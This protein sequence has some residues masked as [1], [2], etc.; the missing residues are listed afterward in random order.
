MISINSN[1]GIVRYL[2]TIC[3]LTLSMIILSGCNSNNNPISPVELT[4]NKSNIRLYDGQPWKLK[5]LI[6]EE[7]EEY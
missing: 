4:A 3:Y 1:G 7:V 2:I 5:Q 6:G